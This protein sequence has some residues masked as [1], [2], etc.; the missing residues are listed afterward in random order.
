M[1]R[2]HVIFFDNTLAHV[3]SLLKVGVMQIV[4]S[5]IEA[6]QVNTELLL[7]DPVEAL[8]RWSHDPTL[9]SRAML[10]SGEELTAVELQLR[11]LA[12][13]KEFVSRNGGEAVVPRANEILELWEDTLLKLAAGDFEQLAGRLDWVLKLSILQ[14]VLD[15]R[16]DL[17][18][19]SPEIKHLDHLYSSLDPSEGLYWAYDNGFIE[20]VA[21]DEEVERFT[22]GPPE[23]TRAWTRAMLLRWAGPDDVDDVDWDAIRFKT[24]YERYRTLYRKLELANPLAFTKRAAEG[25]FENATNLDELLDGLV[26]GKEIRLEAA[27]TKKVSALAPARIT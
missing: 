27:K 18:W 2:L 15:E 24:G 7:D 26:S 25:A 22:I 5:M 6:E 13:A 10:T 17:T 14:Q 9:K 8:L 21:S 12:D 3:A 23:D 20:R 11:F 4:L 1:A 16:P 19:D